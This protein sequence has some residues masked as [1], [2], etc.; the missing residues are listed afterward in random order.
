MQRKGEVEGWRSGTL[1]RTS[2]G[3][4]SAARDGW[5]RQGNTGIS[6]VQQQWVIRHVGHEG[7][8]TCRGFSPASCSLVQRQKGARKQAFVTSKVAPPPTPRTPASAPSA[9]RRTAAVS[10]ES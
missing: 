4:G 8:S 7:C 6:T 9:D 10:V 3:H 2:Y 5:E 1:A